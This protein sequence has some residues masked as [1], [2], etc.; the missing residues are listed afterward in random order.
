LTLISMAGL[1]GLRNG[2]RRVAIIPVLNAVVLVVE[3]GPS[4]GAH[5]MAII[6][7]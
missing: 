5:A 3:S 4:D 1:P 7:A 2:G 6:F